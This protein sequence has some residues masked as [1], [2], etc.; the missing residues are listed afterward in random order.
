MGTALTRWV[1]PRVRLAVRLE[2]R[3]LFVE[4]GWSGGST[5]RTSAS[6]RGLTRQSSPLQSVPHLCR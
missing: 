3:G 4:G 2:A 6:A 5:A 1:A